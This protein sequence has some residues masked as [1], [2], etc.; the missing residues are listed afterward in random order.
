MSIIP[1]AE[2]FAFDGNRIGCVVT[3]G[4]TSTPDEVRELG[5]RLAQA[6]Y[7]VRGPL[8][9]GHGTTPAEM[10]RTTWQDW[11]GAVEAATDE[12]IAR[13]EQVFA[14]GL[15]MGGMLSLYVAAH[16]SV[17]GVVA[18]AAPILLPDWRM[19]LAEVLRPFVPAVRKGKEVSNWFDR[20]AQPQHITYQVYPTQSV[21]ELKK[22]LRVLNRTLPQVDAPAQLIY[23]RNDLSIKPR[24]A[25]VIYNR[26]AST[27]KSL[28]WVDKSRHVLTQD[29]ER[30]R[31]FAAVLNFVAR[32]ASESN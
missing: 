7:T 22:F 6:G 1:G 24:H 12:L 26:L 31:V 17:S 32:I 20:T 27:D 9:P 30:E 3:H 29:A 28:M 16:R 25:R 2:P 11:Y 23:S 18:I 15:S 5:S 14:I 19:H 4:F 13:C 8:L 10:E 21:I